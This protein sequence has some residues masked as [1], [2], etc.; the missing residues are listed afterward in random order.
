MSKLTINT[1][2]NY[3]PNF[4]ARKRNFKQIKY[5]IFHYTGMKNENDAIKKLTSFKS[6]VSCH[7]F[8]KSN[9]KILTLVP[10]L[11]NAWHAGISS[12]KNK[13]LLNKN[14][15]GIEIDN[16]GHNF[17]YKK[18]SKKQ[19]NS[20]LVLSKFLLKKYKINPKNILGHSDIAP[21]RKKDPGEKFP[22][23]YLAK[24]KIGFW[25]SVSNNLLKKNR[26][27]KVNN[28]DKKLFFKNLYKIGY[29]KNFKKTHHLRSIVKAF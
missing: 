24:K 3:S 23:K 27:I 4:D 10:D 6:K 1:T 15:I 19:I 26:K 12:W 16:P 13:K 18:F 8:I 20:I 25:H 21:N 17:N 28:K 7:Y 5:I 9:G 2:A 22:W 29:F 14:S 11:Y